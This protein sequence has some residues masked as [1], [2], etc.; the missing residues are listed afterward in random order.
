MKYKSVTSWQGDEHWQITIS[1]G[2]FEDFESAA[3]FGNESID[4]VY[5]D[6]KRGKLILKM[7]QGQD[8]E[9]LDSQVVASKI[10][11]ESFGKWL[12]DD[13]DYEPMDVKI[14]DFAEIE[15]LN[16]SFCGLSYGV[17]DEAGNPVDISDI[18]EKMFQRYQQIMGEITTNYSPIYSEEQLEFF[19]QKLLESLEAKEKG[20]EIPRRNLAQ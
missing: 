4:K 10:K 9:V 20:E 5:Y 6:K 18:S 11:P 3:V 15:G 2:S 13:N 16:G 7:Y 17:E 1:C 19:Y 8:I 14:E 12:V